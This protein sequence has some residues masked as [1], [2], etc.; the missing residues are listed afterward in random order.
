MTPSTIVRRPR[1]P[2]TF[3]GVVAAFLDGDHKPKTRAQYR[4]CVAVQD[5]GSAC[6]LPAR[7]VDMT[8]GGHV[9]FDHRPEARKAVAV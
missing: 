5:D 6:A 2:G 1:L 7:Y 4:R 3:A 9:C 8:R